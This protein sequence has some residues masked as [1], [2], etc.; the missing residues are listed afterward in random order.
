[1]FYVERSDTLE[2][3]VKELQGSLKTL[4]Y[5]F[6]QLERTKQEQLDAANDAIALWE[7]RCE[8]LTNK[9]EEVGEQSSDIVNQWRGR[10]SFDLR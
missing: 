2:E 5:D 9:I 6:Q 8:E 4:E 3:T 7:V 1:M 10:P